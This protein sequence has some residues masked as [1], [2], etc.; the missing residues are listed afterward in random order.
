MDKDNLEK[1]TIVLANEFL[2]SFNINGIL[3]ASKQYSIKLAKDKV[4][5]LSDEDRESLL[6]EIEEKEK[7]ALEASQSEKSE[8]AVEESDTSEKELEPA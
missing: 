7:Q 1:I 2:N 3:E 8:D 4:D 5:S 6:K